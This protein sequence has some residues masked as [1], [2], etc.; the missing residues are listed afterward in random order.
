MEKFSIPGVGGILEKKIDGKEFILVQERWKEDSQ[1]EMGLI[2]IPAGKIRE[3]ENIYDCLRRETKE[4]TG[5]EISEIQ[6]EVDADIVEVNGYKVINYKPFS[7]A[8]NLKGSYP[9]MVQI[10]ICKVRGDLLVESC[11]AKNMR[12]VSLEE[13]KETLWHHENKLYPMHV[14]TLRRYLSFK[15]F[16]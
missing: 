8:Q 2:E 4:E 7:C 9:I 12:W 15:G 11:E 3:F 1:D 14:S 6:G 13:L 10:F 16:S 5:L